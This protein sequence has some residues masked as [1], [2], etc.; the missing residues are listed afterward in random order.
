MTSK[1]YFYIIGTT[2]VEMVT[3]NKIGENTYSVQ[4]HYIQGSDALG[5]VYVLVSEVEEFFKNMSGTLLRRSESEGGDTILKVFKVIGC[6]QEVLV[7]DLESNHHLGNL[8]IRVKINLNE[9]CPIEGIN[10]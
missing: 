8:L 7:Y 4:C 6:Y 10:N 1:N 3:I 5:C 2:D 9:R